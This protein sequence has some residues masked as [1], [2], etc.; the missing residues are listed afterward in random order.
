MRD[1]PDCAVSSTLLNEIDVP[2][3][4]AAVITDLNTESG[5]VLLTGLS[6]D[7][8]LDF[9]AYLPSRMALLMIAP[10]A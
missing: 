6:K 2:P 3:C 5:T 4:E 10:R 1:G 7:A 9:S 8:P